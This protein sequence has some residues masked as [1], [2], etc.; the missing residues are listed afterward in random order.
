MG[1]VDIKR[2]HPTFSK[3]RIL[4]EMHE[5]GLKY[6]PL[7]REKKGSEVPDLPA[8]QECVESSLTSAK[9]SLITMQKC[10]TVMR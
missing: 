10:C 6:K 9:D 7:P 4:Q 5:R 8:Q 3:T 2:I 1:V